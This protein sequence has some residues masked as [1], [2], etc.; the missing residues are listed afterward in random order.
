LKKKI[1]AQLKLGVWT[2]YPMFVLMKIII[3]NILLELMV[4]FQK[5]NFSKIYVENKPLQEKT[6]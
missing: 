1:T 3:Q 4:L 2:K 6:S 5:Y